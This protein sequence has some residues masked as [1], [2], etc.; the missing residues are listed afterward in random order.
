LFIYYLMLR[1][2]CGI[3]M[4]TVFIRLIN[5]PALECRGWL[6]KNTWECGQQ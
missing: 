3:L 4:Q 6:E 2:E 1:M 5:E